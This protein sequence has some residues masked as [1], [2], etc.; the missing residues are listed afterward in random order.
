MIRRRKNLGLTITGSIILL[1]LAGCAATRG[2]GTGLKP[3]ELIEKTILPP[4]PSNV[5][6]ELQ[7]KLRL[8]I[9]ENGN[10]VNVRLENPTGNREWDSMAVESIHH[11]RYT[12]AIANGVP[13]KIW[14]SQTA[15]VVSQAPHPIPIWEIVCETKEKADS[16]V[17]ALRRGARFDSLAVKYSLDPSKNSGGFIGFLDIYQLPQSAWPFLMDL[18][19]NDFTPPVKVGMYYVIYWRSTANVKR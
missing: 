15:R 2:T 16:V 1:L 7:L 8:F 6:G 12:P 19:E 10:V 5:T 3:P 14:I 18:K 4:L 13:I 11:W 9:D 17:D